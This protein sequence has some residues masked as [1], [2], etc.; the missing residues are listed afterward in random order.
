M[1]WII[2]KKVSLETDLSMVV[3]YLRERGIAHQVYEESGEQVLSVTNPHIVDALLKMLDGVEQG[4]IHFESTV[5]PV[6]KN[7]PSSVPSFVDQIKATPITFWLI[8]LSVVGACLIEFDTSNRFVHWL[9]FQN[10]TL[11]EFSKMNFIPRST[12]LQDGEIWRLLT[13]VFLHFGF[14]HVLFNSMWMWDLGRRLELL[15]GKKWYFVFFVVT[16]IVSNAAQSF[17]SPASLFG[18]M[19]GVVYALVGFIMVSH[20]LAPHPLT[21]VAPGILGFMLIWLAVCTTGAIDH[22]VGGSVANA[23]HVGGL[24]AGIVFAL[25]AVSIIKIKRRVRD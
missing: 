19:S 15:L 6:P 23:A 13:P 18:G 14:F 3:G 2:V 25:V 5:N 8:I 1:N 21:A 24:V 9:S 22:F 12:S 20:R 7:K 10:F 16:A 17:W 4:T 11:N